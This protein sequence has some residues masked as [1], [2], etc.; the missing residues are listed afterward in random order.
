MSRM[1]LSKEVLHQYRDGLLPPA[2]ANDV[3]REIWAIGEALVTAT[4]VG[5]SAEEVMAGQIAIDLLPD[6]LAL[7]GKVRS[8][9]VLGR[10]RQIVEEHLGE[11]SSAD[12]S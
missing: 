5:R 3:E 11:S 2:A 10:I 6:V 8:A 12:A 7:M 9:G 4:Q 1:K